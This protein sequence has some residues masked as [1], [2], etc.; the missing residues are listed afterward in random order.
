M[1]CL[2]LLAA[3]ACFHGLR[4]LSEPGS[5]LLSSV[6]RAG[7]LLRARVSERAVLACCA[8]LLGLLSLREPGWLFRLAGHGAS[9]LL[10]V[11]PGLGVGQ[12]SG[13]G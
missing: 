1:S 4:S 12:Q 2:A 10:L 3:N 13:Y 11:A 7:W 6:G 9:S 5:V 8:G